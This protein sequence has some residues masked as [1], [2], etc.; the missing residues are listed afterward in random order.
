MAGLQVA[1]QAEVYGNNLSLQRRVM[2]E[3]LQHLFLAYN[4][5]LS[6]RLKGQIPLPLPLPLPLPSI[7]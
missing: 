6:E 3:L 4:T 1:V 2:D 5:F 7:S